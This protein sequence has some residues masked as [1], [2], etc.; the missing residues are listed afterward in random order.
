ML[1]G[2]GS[3]GAY[4]VGVW[5]YFRERGERFDIVC[6]TSIGAINGALVT[7]GEFEKC[8]AL[9]QNVAANKVMRNGLDFRSDIFKNFNGT[10]QGK[11]LAFAKTYVQNKG[12]DISP[13]VDLVKHSIDPHAVK[14]SPIQLGV[15]TVSYPL[16]KEEDVLV[17][18]LPENQIL[19]YLHAS[20]ACW[21][22]FPVYQIGE[23]KYVD[24]GYR[25]NLPIDFAIR[26]GADDI[27]AVMLHAVPKM[28]Q[29]PELMTLPFVKTIR[30]SRNLGTIMDF[31]KNTTAQNMELGYLD[32]LRSY[33]Q[34]WGGY[35]YFTK[36]SSWEDFAKQLTYRVYRNHLYDSVRLKTALG[37]RPE[38]KSQP[39]DTLIK[40]AETMGKWLTIDFR[41]IYR[42][43]DFFRLALKMIS[44][45]LK[46]KE[47]L[48][49]EETK[50]PL[51]KTEEATNRELLETLFT[52][53]QREK[54]EKGTIQ[55]E[56][57][58]ESFFYQELF[59]L[60]KEKGYFRGF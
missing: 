20:S 40:L 8:Q 7:T 25:N 26:L 43:E 35:Y 6:G 41:K 27:V 42:L 31:S 37:F 29:H 11:L 13:F 36:E 59:T 9:W 16:M 5:K 17:Q 18:N 54:K 39:I 38:E 60:L 51:P 45:S 24:G 34:V 49:S 15:V 58:P 30:P 55:Y 23:K 33:H 14:E 1:C 10:T 44:E 53:T 56:K 57:H 19:D 52:E 12:A 50:K 2:G 3:L 4:E 48:P 47:A 46:K 22:I 21:P 28:P 32:A